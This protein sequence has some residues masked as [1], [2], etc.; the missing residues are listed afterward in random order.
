MEVIAWYTDVL[1]MDIACIVNLARYGIWIMT[2]VGIMVIHLEAW[3]CMLV[4]MAGRQHIREA[5]QDLS[6]YRADIQL[7]VHENCSEQN[8][9]GIVVRCAE[10]TGQDDQAGGNTEG[11]TG[12][13]DGGWMI[14][15]SC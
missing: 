8:S 1:S 14:Q 11:R 13:E 12:S 5:D 10:V 3:A 4:T 6:M 15:D 2:S 7:A 9:A